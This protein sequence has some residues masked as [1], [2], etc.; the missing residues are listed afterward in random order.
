MNRII[1]SSLLA[2]ILSISLCSCDKDFMEKKSSRDV[3]QSQMF[4]TTEGGMM[5]INGIHKLMY[6]PSLSSSY[7][8]GGYQTFMIWMD[9]MGE[10]LVY[11]RA[12]AQFQSQAKWS[13]HRSATS[14]HLLY[15]YNLF[16][17]FIANAN[18][19]IMN[20]DEAKGTQEEKNYIKG[21]A[22]AYRAF[23]YFN[24]VQCWGERYK[25]EGNN[26][27][28]GVIIRTEPT[29]ENRPRS[30][31]E[32][33]YELINSDLDKAMELLS[34]ITKITKP[35]KSHIDIHVAR[36]L[37]ARVL[38]TQGKWLEAA[39]MASLVVEQS[40]A[41][42][43]DDTYTTFNNRMSDQSNTE[44][45]WGKKGLDEQAGLLRDFH[46]FMSNKNVSFNK[47]TPRAIY[48]LLYNKISNTDVRKT[49]W[50]PR[51]QDPKTKPAPIVPT[52]GYIRNYMA[53]K[54]LLANE[55]AK[56]GDVPWMRLP[57][58][59]LIVAE[60]YARAGR[61]SEAA[62]ALYPL[63][64]HRDPEYELS[65]NTGD[66]LIDEIM[67]QRRIELWGE[68]FRFL[69]LKRLN[70]PLDRGPKP[71]T[72]LGYSD[73][74]WNSNTKMPK[75]VDPKASN[76]NMYDGH[77]MG[78]NAR[79]REAGTNKWQFLFPRKEIETN[80]LCEQNPLS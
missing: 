62:N 58:M 22:Y 17:Q 74:P 39:N 25:E 23:A 20:I 26:S 35:N 34:N 69:D 72:E 65:T 68:G 12:N 18:M 16:Y 50:F 61:Y 38:L 40:E 33:V 24:L 80:P 78:E 31:V 36:G 5:A 57:E 47:N 8:Q 37:K 77:P 66:K 14:S 11:T 1:I 6:T 46:S 48:N 28:L 41:K 29:T 13:T 64:H 79:K 49:L 73:A 56:C 51:A 3:D 43:Q 70:L 59:M 30:T 42:L 60:G 21:Q 7:A 53:N 4:E 27:Q 55:N 10:D 19:I 63:A 75:N 76:Y 9:M 71:R 52:G 45:L 44:W 54:F 15:H 32:E 67:F 2:A